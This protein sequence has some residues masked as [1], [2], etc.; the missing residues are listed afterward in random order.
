MRNQTLH[1]NV[2]STVVGGMRIACLSRD[3]TARLILDAVNAPT[4][5]YEFPIVMTSANGQVLSEYARSNTIKTL[6]D[7]ADLVSADGQPMVLA[8]RYVSKQPLPE[9]VATTDLFH[10]VSAMATPGARYF[11][12]GAT[13]QEIERAV[14][15]AQ[16]LYPH[17]DI[18]G[19]SHGHISLEEEAALADRIN[20]LEPDILWIGMGVPREQE[21]C[22]RHRD[23]LNRV[24]VIKT[25]GGLFNFLSGTRSRAPQWMQDAGLEW[26]YRLSLEPKRLLRRYFVTNCHS[27][28]LLMF[29]TT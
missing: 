24:K 7:A 8:S 4:G 2:P 5:A 3:E 18:V 1:A 17:V 19:Y 14:Q 15:T 12:L 23:R 29:R 13:R 9:R 16:D 26:L 6:F 28:I 21:F 22:V 25:S 10:D 11:M 20:D 27:L